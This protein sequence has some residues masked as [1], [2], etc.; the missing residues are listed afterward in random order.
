MVTVNATPIPTLNKGQAVQ[1]LSGVS[2]NI[3]SNKPIFVAQ[4]ANGMTF[5]YIIGD[6]F[7]MNITPVNQFIANS[8]VVIPT[9]Y[10]YNYLTVIVPN[11]AIG[12][13]M[14][15]GSI[16][17]PSSFS[18][19]SSSGYSGAKILVMPGL[20]NITSSYNFGVWAYGFRNYESYGFQGG[21][22]I[23]LFTATVTPTITHTLTITPTHSITPTRT[24]TRTF[25][26]TRTY[27][28]T[29][30]FTPTR[31]E[32]PTFTITRTI[33]PSWTFSLT[34]T[35]TL[36]RTATM[37]FTN[38]RSP[39]ITQTLS[40]S[41]TFTFTNTCT[42]TFTITQSSTYTESPVPSLTNTV[43]ISP[44]FTKSN[45][46]TVTPS[47][48]PTFSITFTFSY[49][50]TLTPSFTATIYLSPTNTTTFTHTLTQT[51]TKTITTTPTIDLNKP[52]EINLIGSFPENDKTNIVF[53]LSR[54][55]DIIIKI[56]TVS[57]EVVLN[58]RIIG[59]SGYNCFSWDGLNNKKRKVAS[60]IFIYKITAQKES[61]VVYVIDKLYIIK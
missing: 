55:A 46:N 31:T 12:N 32:T 54:D 20:H 51:N 40:V 37:T 15:D 14:L 24:E 27:S 52:L 6:P 1:F 49:T 7:M 45:T 59:N 9:G 36:T 39:T 28:S 30:T 60:G 34:R 11:S 41:Q 23:N 10:S 3:L 61:E 18:S 35:N 21:T 53:L 57:G 17:N 38:T 5:D 47:F 13:I 8:K 29:R 33:T 22:G 44:T 19:I 56:F 26:I 25:T 48:T 2:Q 4:Y 42:I 16:I 43:E 50:L 58:K